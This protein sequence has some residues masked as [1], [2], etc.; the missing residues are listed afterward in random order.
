MFS[1]MLPLVV[2]SR[3]PLVLILSGAL[4]TALTCALVLLTPLG[5]PYSA[6]RP[7]RV[8]LF[9]TRR[10][11][12]GPAPSV[13]TFYW[14]PELD[15]NTPHS[16]DAY[17]AGMREARA[18]SAEECARWVYCGAPYFL[19]VLS[20]VARG[21]RLPAPAP[22]LAELRVRAELRPAGEGA[23]ELLLELDGPSHAV[24]ILAP[25]A[26]VRV[27]HCA[28]LGGPPQPGPRWGARDTHFPGARWLQLSAAGHAMHGAAMRHA[29]HA[30]LLAALPPHAAPTGWGVDLHL[31]EL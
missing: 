29:E 4:V 23:R 9:H 22:P 31:L 12:H 5:A 10:T 18:S 1:W 16:L 13:D 3:R 27:A 19:P 24:V 25:A 21:H 14:M 20:L 15:V 28:E 7:Q 30:R 17:V 26:G 2:A 6:E 11:L 8:M